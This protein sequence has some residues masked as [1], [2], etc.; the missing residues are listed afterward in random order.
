V[1]EKK[2]SIM[3][4]SIMVLIITALVTVLPMTTRTTAATGV[5]SYPTIS[6]NNSQTANRNNDGIIQHTKNQQ[7]YNS[8]Q[9]MI[10]AFKTADSL[11]NQALNTQS[12]KGSRST[13]TAE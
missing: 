5:V 2:S 6:E 9:S 7:T 12:G 8:T 11:L 13:W 4:F 10:I 3:M 1:Q